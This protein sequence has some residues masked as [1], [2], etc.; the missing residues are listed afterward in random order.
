MRARELWIIGALAAAA[1][2]PE[3]PPPPSAASQ[4]D[5]AAASA[6]NGVGATRETPGGSPA[7]S[8]GAASGRRDATAGPTAS[9]QTSTNASGDGRNR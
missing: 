6:P 7:D 4:S 9:G 2:S 3:A 5:N 8:G 1:C